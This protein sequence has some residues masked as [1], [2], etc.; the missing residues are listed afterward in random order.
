MVT[1]NCPLKVRCIIWIWYYR[2]QISCCNVYWNEWMNVFP[3][4]V[5]D[6]VSDK[7]KKKCSPTSEDI[8]LQ[9]KA[10]FSSFKLNL[11]TREIHLTEIAVTGLEL[12]TTM[13]QS[14][15]SFQVSLSTFYYVIIIYLYYIIISILSHYYYILSHYYLNFIII[16]F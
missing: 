4:D 8:D 11:L 16:D 7:E 10:R 3:F 12:T 13:Q 5:V 14:L 9:L 6:V 1:I 2:N 15:V